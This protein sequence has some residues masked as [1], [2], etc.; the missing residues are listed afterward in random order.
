MCRNYDSYVLPIVT[1]AC[2][3]RAGAA[4]SM[5]KYPAVLR[6]LATAESKRTREISFPMLDPAVATKLSIAVTAVFHAKMKSSEL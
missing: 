5:N 1:A 2:A 3:K 4:A 6:S